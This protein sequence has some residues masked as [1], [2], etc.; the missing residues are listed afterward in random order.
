MVNMIKPSFRQRASE[1]EDMDDFS[2][3]GEALD[4]ALRFL[5]F[6]NR[7]LGGHQIILQ[8]LDKTLRQL[9]WVDIQPG[10]HLLDLGCGGGDT[11][12][13]VA[14]W[15]RKQELDLQITGIDANPNILAFARKNTSEHPEINYIEGNFLAQDFDW[16]PYQ[17]VVC[18]LILHHFEDEQI[19]SLLKKFPKGTIVI[20]NDLQRHRLAYVLFKVLCFITSAPPMASKDGAL[21]VRKGFR[22]KELESFMRRCDVTHYDLSWRWAFRYQLILA[23]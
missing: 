19:L 2:V 21:S 4:G 18:S 12:M 6:V 22:R 5:A 15:S 9:E 11:L 20:I 7:F 1:T 10:M 23:T 8:A 3:Q 13:E 16:K 17:I 14:K